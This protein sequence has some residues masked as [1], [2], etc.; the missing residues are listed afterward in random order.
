MQNAYDSYQFTQLIGKFSRPPVA[1]A[2]RVGGAE[3]QR[4]RRVR[5]LVVGLTWAVVL[6]VVSQ[7]VSVPPAVTARPP[8]VRWACLPAPAAG[9]QPPVH[10]AANWR[11]L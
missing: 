5:E 1:A 8:P 7:P 10:A 6:Q 9:L 4:L 11:Y 3:S 2:A